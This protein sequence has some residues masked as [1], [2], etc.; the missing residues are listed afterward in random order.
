M[1]GFAGIL[2]FDARLAGGGNEALFNFRS[3]GLPVRLARR[4]PGDTLGIVSPALTDGPNFGIGEIGR[5]GAGETDID[6]RGR[7]P[8]LRVFR[9]SPCGVQTSSRSCTR[10]GD[11]GECTVKVGGS[12]GDERWKFIDMGRPYRLPENPR[13]RSLSPFD[14]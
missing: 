7:W 3:A 13:S 2:G 5:G 4:D 8:G 12:C 11:L 6:S 1:A 10:G 9:L 14:C